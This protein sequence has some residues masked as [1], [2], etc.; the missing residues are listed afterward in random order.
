[1]KRPIPSLKDQAGAVAVTVAILMFV[2][3]GIAA[4]AIDIGYLLVTRNELQNV[5]DAAALA[6]ASKLGDNYQNMS[7]AEQLQY[8]C[9]MP[10]WDFPCGD[11]V[12]V[13]QE[14]G[15]ANRA[16]QVDIFIDPDDVFIGVWNWAPASPSV[17][18]FTE[19]SA[20]PRAVR[21]IARRDESANNPITTFL[22]GV[23]DVDE[24]S[25]SA[26]A[27]ASLGGQDEAAE[28][29]LELP[30][31]IDASFFPPN[32][33]ACGSQIF[34]SPT[35]L[36]CAGWTQFDPRH[37]DQTGILNVI[38]GET[39]S[40]ELHEGDWFEYI[41]GDI[42]NLLDDLQWRFRD[43]GYDVDG[44][45]KQITDP[46]T[47]EPL[48]GALPDE[49]PGT[50]AMKSA[51]GERLNYEKRHPLDPTEPRNRHVW[52]TKVLVYAAS[53]CDNANQSRRTVGF[54]RVDITDVQVQP[55]NTI[56]GTIT[57]DEVS[58]EPASG[59]GPGFGTFGNIP[60]LVQ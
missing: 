60:K 33:G 16:G 11:I 12:A 9:G 30:V 45:G 41:G 50:V 44:Q 40:P 10:D 42:P 1:M 34:F 58:E 49:F 14:V 5:A 36:S 56:V 15:L 46:D 37:V 21:V 52:E 3:V 6:A 29:E 25:V 22:A 17:D 28:G 18:P 35:G 53:G 24:M 13:A 8:D 55:N 7:P 51:E 38:T 32:S 26:V 31:G 4:L 39:E 23:L 54:A 48:F 2:L 27:T 20:Q 43:L 57:C 47:D 19:Q 59:S